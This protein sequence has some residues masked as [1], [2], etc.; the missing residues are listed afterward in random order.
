MNEHEPKEPIWKTQKS[1]TLSPIYK[2]IIL[3]KQEYKNESQSPPDAF[4]V[5]HI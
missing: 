3:G 1:C 2:H 4:T 5:F